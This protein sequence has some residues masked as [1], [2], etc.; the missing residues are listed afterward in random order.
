MSPSTEG[1]CISIYSKLGDGLIRKVALC[2]ENFEY[3]GP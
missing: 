1:Y 2:N 3:D